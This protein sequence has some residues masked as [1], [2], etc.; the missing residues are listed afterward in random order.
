M[1]HIS[2]DQIIE[3]NSKLSSD[4]SLLGK[5]YKSKKKAKHAISVDHNLVAD[6]EKEG[7]EVDDVL[8]T[9]T[10]PLWT[11]CLDPSSSP[12]FKEKNVSLGF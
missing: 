6:Y 1:A 10:K 3:L 11:T 12:K 4:S 2:S 7:W 5:I 8:K 9:K